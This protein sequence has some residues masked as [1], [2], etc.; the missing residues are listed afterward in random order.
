[1]SKIQNRRFSIL[2]GTILATL[3]LTVPLVLGQG[4]APVTVSQTITL[5]RGWNAFYVE[6]APTAP[7]QEVFARWP[8]NSGSSLSASGAT[9]SFVVAG[10]GATSLLRHP[11]HPQHDGLRWDFT[12]PAPSGDDFS[13]YVSE[14]KPE[15]FSVSCRIALTL[16][17]NGGEALWNPENTKSGTCRWTFSNLMRQGDITI[18]GPMTIKRVSP[19]AEIVLE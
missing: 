9:F 14:V 10:D 5:N 6:V 19:L 13:N 17:L 16:D 1:M 3:F 12:T 8:V 2:P 18:S 7:A 11:L 4:G 15:T